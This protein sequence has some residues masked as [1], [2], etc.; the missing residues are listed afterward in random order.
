MRQAD[1]VPSG[2]R[3]AE[4]AEEGPLVKTAGGD[5][6]QAAGRGNTDVISYHV[7]SFTIATRCHY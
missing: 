5:Q 4:P 2:K 1:T 6:G 7:I 3:Y